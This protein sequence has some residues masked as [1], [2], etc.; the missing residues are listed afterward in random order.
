MMKKKSILY[1]IAFCCLIFSESCK[2]QTEKETK[3]KTE[4]TNADKMVQNSPAIENSPTNL[5]SEFL[6]RLEKG[7]NLSVLM[8]NKWTFIYHEDNRCDG[9]TDG[10]KV[11]LPGLAIDK[12]ISILVEN[13]GEGWACAKKKP[14]KFNLDFV[15]KEKVKNW[16]RFKI[17]EYSKPEE[18]I[19]YI[20]GAGES[21]YIIIY[22]EKIDDKYLILKL[23]YRSE[24]PG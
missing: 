1:F 16:D 22:F 10:S 21:D 3:N 6:K 23:E 9:S 4:I 13:D 19:F 8:S 12:T 18:N 24:D 2:N 20:Q 15:L 11:D 14:S 5:A 7:Q 17:A